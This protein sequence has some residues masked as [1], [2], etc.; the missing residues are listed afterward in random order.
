[1]IGSFVSKRFINSAVSEG[2]LRRYSS[3]KGQQQI[4]M[5]SYNSLILFTT[6]KNYSYWSTYL[7]FLAY[8]PYLYEILNTALLP[9]SRVAYNLA[10]FS[11]HLSS[12]FKSNNTLSAVVNP[13]TL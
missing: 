4:W 2:T 13:T 10:H 6:A 1:M 9:D 5:P 3:S 12:L 8:R 7:G 11:L